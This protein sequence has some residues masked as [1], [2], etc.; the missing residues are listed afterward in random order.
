MQFHS[1]VVYFSIFLNKDYKL[2]FEEF[3]TFKVRNT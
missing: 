1:F 2:V 3:C